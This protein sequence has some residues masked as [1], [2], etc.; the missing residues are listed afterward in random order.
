[1]GGFI[2][3][4]LTEFQNGQYLYVDYKRCYGVCC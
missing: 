2:P 1:M 3:S 4:E